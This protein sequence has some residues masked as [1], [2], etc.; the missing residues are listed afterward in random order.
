MS[1]ELL[2]KACPFCGSEKG[3]YYVTGIEGR[4]NYGM[5]IECVACLGRGPR[6]EANETGLA[7]AIAAWNHRAPAPGVLLSDGE[8]KAANLQGATYMLE[9]ILASGTHDGDFG[10]KFYAKDVVKLA[11]QK[12]MERLANA[13][14]RQRSHDAN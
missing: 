12:A 8:R 10:R 2:L 5:W 4:E 9:A 6:T 11:G 14:T 3:P 13:A 7:E 1:D